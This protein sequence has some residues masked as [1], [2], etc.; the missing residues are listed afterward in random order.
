MGVAVM[1]FQG[2]KFDPTRL[3]ERVVS[4]DAVGDQRVGAFRGGFDSVEHGAHHRLRLVA[5]VGVPADAVVVRADGPTVLDLVGED[6]D[7]RMSGERVFLK[8]VPLRFAKKPDEGHKIL[9]L[10]KLIS[11]EDSAVTVE[12]RNDRRLFRR[13]RDLEI[14]AQDLGAEAVFQRGDPHRFKAVHQRSPGTAT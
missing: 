10:E 6:V 8:G 7:E 5:I 2:R 1:E 12:R 13:V 9:G 11:E 4:G 3:R 14:H